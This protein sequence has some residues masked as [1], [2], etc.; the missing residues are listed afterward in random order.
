V[1]KLTAAYTGIEAIGHDMCPKSCLAFTG[2]FEDMDACPMCGMLHWK[3]KILQGMCGHTKV[4]AQKFI[5]IPIGP[6]LQVV[7]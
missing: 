4:A 1:E 6:Q 3:E 7:Y 5:T 2:P